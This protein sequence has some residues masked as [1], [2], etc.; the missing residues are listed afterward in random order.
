MENKKIFALMSYLPFLCLIPLLKE[1]EDEFVHF[2]AKQGFILFIVEIVGV[3]F[4]FS[5]Y[6]LFY[7]IPIL[8]YIFFNFFF[9]LF[10]LSLLIIMIIGMYFVLKGEKGEILWIGEISKN[11]KI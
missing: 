11:L 2:H 7:E 5:L 9:S 10:L 3:I 4:F 1:K 8:K 6:L